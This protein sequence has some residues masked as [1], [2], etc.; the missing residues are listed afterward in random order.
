[1]LSLAGSIFLLLASLAVSAETAVAAPRRAIEAAAPLLPPLPEKRI[2][3]PAGPASEASEIPLRW[4]EAEIEKAQR[5]C[6]KIV[7][8]GAYDLEPL[9]PIRKGECGAPAPVRLKA[10]PASPMLKLHPPAI[11]TCAFAARLRE[12]IERVVQ[13]TAIER[14]G[15]PIARITNIS[16]YVCRHRY[17]DP[18]KKISQHA[19]ASALDIAEFIT[20]KGDRISVLEN[21]PGDDERAAFLRDVHRGACQIFDTA[22][23]PEANDAH[24]NHFHLD[25]GSGGVCE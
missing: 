12:W 7:A 8:A 11:V 22:L 18:A 1:M 23:G 25:I 24:K 10:I 6:I 19:R 15:T 21:W 20:A 13:P 9:S 3:A 14:L 2:N 4:S 16:S 5:A 17:S